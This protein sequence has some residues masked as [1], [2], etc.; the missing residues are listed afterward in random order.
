MKKSP[1]CS[2]N[3][4]R[5]PALPAHSRLPASP[6]HNRLPASPAHNRLPALPVSCSRLPASP[7]HCN[8]LHPKHTTKNASFLSLRHFTKFATFNVR[9]LLDDA[10][11]SLLANVLNNYN[12]SV[13]GLN[14]VRRLDSGSITVEHPDMTRPSTLL[15]SGR[16]DIRQ[17]GVGILLSSHAKRCL[18]DWSPV[19]SRIIRARFITSKARLTIICAYAPTRI[20][21]QQQHTD[22][23]KSLDTELSNIPSHDMI[24]V[25]GD[26]NAHLGSSRDNFRQTLGPFCNSS[27][28][29]TSGERLLDFCQR[30]NLSVSNTFFR[31]RNIQRN[32]Y[33][34]PDG[35]HHHLLDLI[36]VN[37]RFRSSVLDTRVRRNARSFVD[38]DHELVV[39]KVRLKLR[40]NTATATRRTIN[41]EQLSH[42]RD[43]ATN[44]QRLLNEHLPPTPDE[45]SSETDDKSDDLE[46]VWKSFKDTI[47]SSAQEAAGFLRRRPTPWMTPQLQNLVDL[48]AAAFIRSR[49]NPT[50]QNIQDYRSLRKQVRNSSRQC[51]QQSWS[52]AATELEDDMKHNRTYSAFSR[53]RQFLRPKGIRS[54]ELNDSSGNPLSTTPEKLNRWTEYFSELLNTDLKID[55]ELLDSVDPTASPDDEPPP[56]LQMVPTPSNA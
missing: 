10:K 38:S 14:E 49:D 3:R 22:F 31:H 12:I 50:P 28:R 8:V 35:K 19:S 24:L 46:A 9:T 18:S 6:A 47:I 39:S 54:E 44:F 23:Y 48:K 53:I 30:N 7:A 36:L 52:K 27:P 26:F 51:K 43:T 21:S 17:H 40:V 16:S 15:W 5:L 1:T 11:L 20:S 42:D 56:T 37:H 55:Q 34:S 29:N 25:L 13:C 45:K 2:E 4:S 33:T 32:T 41:S